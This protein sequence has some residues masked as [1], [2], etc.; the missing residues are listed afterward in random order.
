MGKWALGAALLLGA[1]YTIW[2]VMVAG[3]FHP[4]QCA[5]NP[6]QGQDACDLVSF[7]FFPLRVAVRFIETHDKF[8]VVVGT[9]VIAWFTATLWRATSGLKD[10]TDKLWD[11][12]E[13]QAKLTRKSLR[14]T[15][16]LHADEQ[17]PWLSISVSNVRQ[18]IWPSA[19]GRVLFDAQ[20]QNTGRTPAV[21]ALVY[22][23]LIRDITEPLG[24][25]RLF[26]SQCVG[27]HAASTRDPRSAVVFPGPRPPNVNVD[28]AERGGSIPGFV[29]SPYLLFVCI[30]YRTK[31]GGRT[32]HSAWA[33]RVDTIGGT[34]DEIMRRPE[35]KGVSATEVRFNAI[36]ISS[37]D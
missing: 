37:A 16:R 31:T 22:D 20:V 26:I 34:A 27:D 17:R 18:L 3:G 4:Y 13:R 19:I 32:R 10:S 25:F 28:V 14:I 7:A 35:L 6:K 29:A 21:D 23:M 11:A 33:Y 8:F 24:N 1:A 9:G 36:G 30:C 12:G 2:L 5:A 15:R